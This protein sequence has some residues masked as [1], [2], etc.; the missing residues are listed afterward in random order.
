MR[1]LLK[2][3]LKRVIMLKNFIWDQTTIVLELIHIKL[4]KYN[5]YFKVMLTVYKLSFLLISYINHH[6]NIYKKYPRSSYRK[7]VHYLYK[8]PFVI[9]IFLAISCL[10]ELIITKGQLH[11]NL[12]LIF[13]YLILRLIISSLLEFSSYPWE[14][15]C[16]IADYSLLKWDQPRYS[17]R[18]WLWFDS[19]RSDFNKTP[20]I[21]DTL[22]TVIKE[23]INDTK[24]KHL[25]EQKQFT[26]V[27]QKLI[28]NPS[29]P[30]CLS[31]KIAY[32]KWSNVRWTHTSTLATKVWHP[33]TSLFAK[34]AV[35]YGAILNNSWSHFATIEKIKARINYGEILYK[36]FENPYKIKP[37]KIAIM[38]EH[39]LLTNYAKIQE[40]NVIVST[41]DKNIKTNTHNQSCDDIQFNPKNATPPI[42]DIRT[43]ALDQKATPLAS[44][45]PEPSS[46]ILSEISPIEY[47]MVLQN[48]RQS[49]LNN[50]ELYL[51]HILAIDQVLDSLVQTSTQLHLHQI[52]WLENLHLFPD[53][54]IPPIRVPLNFCIDNLMPQVLV[55]YNERQL[56]LEKISN[57]LYEH[58]VPCDYHKAID[59]MDGSFMQKILEEV[60]S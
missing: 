25:I 40:R 30:Y 3:S 15:V 17:Q 38:M 49:L 5:T 34:H 18:F 7:L 33:M 32:Q 20:E 26:K 44:R 6:P 23:K 31:V 10:S 14:K 48:F 41:Y 9:P 24:R 16:C 43:H 29:T 22:Q 8:K 13:I 47:E 1:N 35:D 19:I 39:N 51:N 60:V 28:K 55:L 27:S 37:I 57:K 4:L 21:S 53:N 2:K 52:V 12:Y 36:S 11:F 56:L 45:I 59:I 50:I 54:Y 46:K 58:E 42:Q